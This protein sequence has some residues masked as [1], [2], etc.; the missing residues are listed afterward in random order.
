MT[1]RLTALLVLLA[2]T[3]LLAQQGLPPSEAVKAMTPEQRAKAQRDLNAAAA[4]FWDVPLD[5]AKA[6]LRRVMVVMRDSMLAVD[7]ESVR[8]HRATT[9]AV[10][11]STARRLAERCRAAGRT[12]VVT[13]AKIQPLVTSVAFGNE[14]LRQYRATIVIVEG[15]MSACDKTLGA[16]M[17]S[18]I[19]RAQTATKVSSVA[20]R[21]EFASGA[22]LQ[23][24]EIPLR[25]KGVTPG[26]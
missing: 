2:S 14:V 26:G 25:P 9:D 8:L 4:M 18:A 16:G 10:A 7:A 23:A 17:P 11:A 15:E 13:R 20:Q 5:S 19:A 1:L 24:L 12:A 22:L 6:Q 21:Y 3:P